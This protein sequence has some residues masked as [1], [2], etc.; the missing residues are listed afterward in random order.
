MTSDDREAIV[1][2][3]VYST[4]RAMRQTTQGGRKKINKN[5]IKIKGKCLFRCVLGTGIDIARNRD[6]DLGLEMREWSSATRE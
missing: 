2:G 4:G 6:F 1:R 3:T 5:K